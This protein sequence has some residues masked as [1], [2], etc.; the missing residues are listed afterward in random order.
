LLR[1]LEL[2]LHVIGGCVT[3]KSSTCVWPFESL[4]R[5]KPT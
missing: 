4:S 2:L 3:V 5:L 1:V